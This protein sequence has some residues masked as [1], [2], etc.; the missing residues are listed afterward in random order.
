MSKDEDH[1]TQALERE[2]LELRSHDIAEDRRRELLRPFPEVRTEGGKLDF[3]RLRLVLGEAVD[4]GRERYGLTWPGK[5]ECFRAIQSPSLGTLRPCPEEGVNFDTTENLI[6]EGDNLEVLKLLQKPLPGR[7]TTRALVRHLV[8][9]LEAAVVV[10]ERAVRH[11]DALEV[12]QH[13][14]EGGGGH[15]ATTLTPG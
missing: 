8:E 5:A 15:Q 13:R 14:V 12:H 7:Q 6:I 9:P 10:V 2:K 4:V 11:T 3:E 1:V